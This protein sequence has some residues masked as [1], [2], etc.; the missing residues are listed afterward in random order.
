[1]GVLRDWKVQTI[2]QEVPLDQIGLMAQEG[3]TN[4]L[5]AQMDLQ[6]AQDREVKALVE[7][8]GQLIL[9]QIL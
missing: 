6:E 3:I 9:D 8:L 7:A 4:L 1:M 5:K 2:N